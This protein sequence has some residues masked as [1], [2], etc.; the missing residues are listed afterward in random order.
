MYAD[1]SIHQGLDD[2][3]VRLHEGSLR[4]SSQESDHQYGEITLSRMQEAYGRRD[5][6][7]RER[8][9][10]KGET[11]RKIE[12]LDGKGIKKERGQ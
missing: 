7:G 10:G 3:K 6:K 2:G 1:S 12:T 11:R 9:E 5:T 4:M 8:S